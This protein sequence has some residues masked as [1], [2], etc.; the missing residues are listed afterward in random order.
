MK[1]MEKPRMRLLTS[2]Q[3][4]LEAMSPKLFATLTLSEL[5]E[6]EAELGH[7]HSQ[8]LRIDLP[9]A[10]QNLHDEMFKYAGRSLRTAGLK[11]PE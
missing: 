11:S 5:H 10:E 4:V 6:E 8:G 3:M 1:T 2:P 9:G 7:L